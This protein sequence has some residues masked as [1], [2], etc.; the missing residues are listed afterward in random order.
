MCFKAHQLPSDFNIKLPL[1]IT[2]ALNCNSVNNANS[3]MFYLS[4][5]GVHSF[6][7]KIGHLSKGLLGVEMLIKRKMFQA[8]RNYDAKCVSIY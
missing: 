5:R 7:G 3:E 2:Q 4:G 8:G 1:P 6:Y